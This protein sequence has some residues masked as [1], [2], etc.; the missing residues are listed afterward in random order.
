VAASPSRDV[1]ARGAEVMR[2]IATLPAGTL[3]V[4][5]H[6][7][8]YARLGA[9]VVERRDFDLVCPGWDW[10]ADPARVL[11]AAL[12]SGRPIA[13]DLADEAWMA[14]REIPN[15]DQVRAWAAGRPSRDLAGFTVISK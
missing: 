11:D 5:G 14:P 7:C 3:V 4:P 2:R 9:T 10:P 12:A 1:A 8:S 15:R 13:L 6:Y